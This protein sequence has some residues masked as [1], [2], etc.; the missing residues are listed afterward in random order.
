MTAQTRTGLHGD[1]SDAQ[2]HQVPVISCTQ[3]E[4]SVLRKF[5]GVQRYPNRDPK[6]MQIAEDHMD[7]PTF[8][9]CEWPNRNFY[10]E[11]RTPIKIF[12]DHYEVV[13][14]MGQQMRLATSVALPGT[15]G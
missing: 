5:Y 14:V 7:A 2:K 9:N 12:Y 11:Q 13:E 15:G 3:E 10:P 8:G 6:A 4:L 1:N